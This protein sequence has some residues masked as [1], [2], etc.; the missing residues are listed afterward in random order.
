[1]NFQY[2]LAPMEKY[3]DSAFRALMHENG[4]DLTFTEM[5]RV[6]ALIRDNS[7]TVE[8]TILKDDVP[9]IIQLLPLK[10]PELQKYISSFEPQRNFQGFNLNIGCPSLELVSLGMGCALIKRT[11]KVNNLAKVIKDAGFNVSIKLRLG[12]NQFEKDKKVYLNLINDVEADFFVVH[13]K[14]GKENE[15]DP[16]DFSVYSECV[17]SGKNIVANGAINAKAQVDDLKTQGIKGVMIGMG[18]IR[19]P[20]IFHELK[21]NNSKNI[22]ELKNEYL[23]MARIHKSRNDYMNTI[24]NSTFK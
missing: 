8:R 6:S 7:S 3:T 1:M 16:N 18:A 9:T 10:E 24:L 13:G 20:N 11:N 4:C 23:E 15:K 21:G 5:A 17:Q 19:N 14:H 22:D 12:L 2:M